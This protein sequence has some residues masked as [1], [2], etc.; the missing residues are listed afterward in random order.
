LDTHNP[1][2]ADE[3]QSEIIDNYISPIIL[4]YLG[5]T[6]ADNPDLAALNQRIRE[7]SKLFGKDEIDLYSFL[8]GRISTTKAQLS[9]ASTPEST[10]LTYV[11]IQDCA[12]L[13]AILSAVLIRIETSINS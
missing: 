12:L 3:A 7:D 1:K 9:T 13:S 4:G 2:T 10:V 11:C 8:I 6:K 5:F